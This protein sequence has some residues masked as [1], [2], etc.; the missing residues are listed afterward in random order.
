M[1][2]A[3]SRRDTETNAIYSYIMF[4]VSYKFNNTGGSDS[5]K[6]KGAREYGMPPAGFMPP[7][8]PPPGMG[9]RMF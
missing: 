9:G 6:G 2:D 4:N 3:L 8:G 5:K 7:A 1:V